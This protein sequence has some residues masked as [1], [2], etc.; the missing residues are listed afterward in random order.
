M[1]FLLPGVISLF[2]P[3]STVLSL[4]SQTIYRKD[5]S[6]FSCPPASPHDGGV[7]RTSVDS[8]PHGSHSEGAWW[9][10]SRGFLSHGL[11]C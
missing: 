10:H 4:S 6:L 1:L 5:C 3:G 8:C 11:L 2:S 9:G 7:N